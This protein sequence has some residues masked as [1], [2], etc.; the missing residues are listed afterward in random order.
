MDQAVL[1]SDRAQLAYKDARSFYSENSQSSNQSERLNT[2]IAFV[3][4]AAVC[5]AV[6]EGVN[7]CAGVNRAEHAISMCRMCKAFLVNKPDNYSVRAA[8]DAFGAVAVLEHLLSAASTGTGDPIKLAL[9]ALDLGQKVFQIGAVAEGLWN[10]WERD[11]CAREALSAGGQNFV[12]SWEAEFCNLA[13]A[14]CKNKLKVSYGSLIRQAKIW[15]DSQPLD[16]RISDFPKTDEGIR[17]GIKR[18]EKKG[19]LHLPGQPL[20]QNNSPTEALG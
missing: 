14:F 19:K 8:R 12:P 1:I 18:L 20:G 9:A 2:A 6:S 16:G 7:S 3:F 5:V 11:K 13:E 15:R 17:K 10:N 4:A